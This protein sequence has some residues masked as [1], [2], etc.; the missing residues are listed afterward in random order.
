[1][2]RWACALLQGWLKEFVFNKFFFLVCVRLASFGER[3][4]PN[5][6]RYCWSRWRESTKH[7]MLHLSDRQMVKFTHRLN[8]YFANF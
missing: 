3:G 8:G 5:G 4:D 2:L 6:K 1:M 7:S